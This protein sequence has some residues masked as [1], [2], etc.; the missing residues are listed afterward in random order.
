MRSCIVLFIIIMISECLFA[1]SP[2]SV[3]NTQYSTESEVTVIDGKSSCDCS[4]SVH[5]GVMKALATAGGGLLLGSVGAIAGYSID[6]KRESGFLC[7]IQGFAVGFSI[8]YTLGAPLG[9]YWFGDVFLDENGSFWVALA[10]STIGMLLS[11]GTVEAFSERIPPTVFYFTLPIGGSILG[12]D[13][14]RRCK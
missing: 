10:G 5:K 3:T 7:G 11:L 4:P 12:Y 9:T 2:D 14:S 13:A 1:Q 8:G 6:C